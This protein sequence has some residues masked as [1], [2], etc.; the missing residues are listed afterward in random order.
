MSFKL[1]PLSKTAS[2]MES[3]RTAAPFPLGQPKKADGPCWGVDVMA[4]VTNVFWNSFCQ[5]STKTAW[6]L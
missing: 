5:T 6:A 3:R 4:G 1:A 2:L